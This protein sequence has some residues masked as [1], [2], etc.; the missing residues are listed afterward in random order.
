MSA[1]EQEIPM[2][3]HRRPSDSRSEADVSEIREAL[4]RMIPRS[5]EDIV[6]KARD[7]FQIGLATAE[8]M[9][10]L[11]ATVEAGPIRDTI[12]EWRIIAFRAIS[13]SV[14]AQTQAVSRSLLLLLGRAAGTRCPWITSAVTEIDIDRRLVRTQNSL[15]RLGARGEGEPPQEDLICVCA[16][17]HRWGVGKRIGAP[18]FFY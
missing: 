5:L 12:T 7:Q 13:L 1:E 16:A 4:E 17:T 10:V 9:A 15:Y 6:R 11:A 8:E 3:D 14:D 18:A 2:T